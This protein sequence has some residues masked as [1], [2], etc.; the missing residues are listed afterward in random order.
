MTSREEKLWITLTDEV[1]QSYQVY[2]VKSSSS[3]KVTT[4]I[5]IVNPVLDEL[6]T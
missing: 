3:Y 2:Q 6:F 5:A 1:G 4:T